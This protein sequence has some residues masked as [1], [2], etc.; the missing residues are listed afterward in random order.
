MMSGEALAKT[1]PPHASVP[2][3]GYFLLHKGWLPFMRAAVAFMQAAFPFSVP[4]QGVHS[5]TVL[6]SLVAGPVLAHC[7]ASMLDQ[8]TFI[9]CHLL[10]RH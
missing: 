4:L 5:D 6:L 2:P 1:P 7:Q 9:T 8:P 10:V 3:E